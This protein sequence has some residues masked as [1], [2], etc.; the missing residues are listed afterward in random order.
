MDFTLYNVSAPNNKLDKVSTGTVV[1]GYSGP[2]TIDVSVM[3]PT[4]IVEDSS[5]HAND[6]NYMYIIDYDR[7]YYIEDII[8]TTAKNMIIFKLRE[9]VL[10]T[11]ATQIKELKCIVKRQTYNYDM[12]LKDEKI[13]VDCRKPVIY[14]SFPHSA[15]QSFATITMLVLGG[16]S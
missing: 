7:F 16:D 14:R 9:D 5:L 15:L 10:Q 8:I 6:C 4:L 13:P 2:A 12:Y 11:F 3:N 1:E